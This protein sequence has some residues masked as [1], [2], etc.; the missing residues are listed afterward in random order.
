MVIK[1]ARNVADIREHMVG[2]SGQSED[3]LS[4]TDIVLT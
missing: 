2:V 4:R 3:R 1:E